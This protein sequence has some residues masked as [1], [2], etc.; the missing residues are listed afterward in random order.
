MTEKDLQ[1]LIRI[2][3][4]ID[5]M[6]KQIITDLDAMAARIEVLLPTPQS[7]YSNDWREEE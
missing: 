3:M 2:R 7:D 6:R 4:G 5:T 1:E